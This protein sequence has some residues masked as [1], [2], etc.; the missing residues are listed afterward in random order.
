MICSLRSAIFTD[1]KWWFAF[2]C[3]RVAETSEIIFWRN[4]GRRKDPFALGPLHCLLHCQF[5]L[6]CISLVRCELLQL[7]FLPFLFTELLLQF[8]LLWPSEQDLLSAQQQ[9]QLNYSLNLTTPLHVTN[10][11]RC[12]SLCLWNLLEDR[13]AKDLKLFWL[14]LHCMDISWSSDLTHHVTMNKS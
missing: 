5:A 3:T 8:S 6:C 10:I 14:S 12:A 1:S 13:S 2:F 7:R 4:R 9:Q 11:F